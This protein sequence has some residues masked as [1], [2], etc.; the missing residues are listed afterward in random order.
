M[1]TVNLTQIF[2]ENVKYDKDFA[3]TPDFIQ[4]I[5]VQL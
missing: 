3:N 4:M 1:A 2:R 5:L